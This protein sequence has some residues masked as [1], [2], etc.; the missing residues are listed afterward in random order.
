MSLEVILTLVALLVGAVLIFLLYRKRKNERPDAVVVEKL[1]MEKLLNDVKVVLA[2]L[3]KEE[4][5]FGKDDPDALTERDSDS[6][7]DRF[8]RCLSRSYG[9]VG[10]PYVFP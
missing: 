6:R 5:S 7:T 2:E 9:E 1:T 3:V 10:G 4:T 8:Q